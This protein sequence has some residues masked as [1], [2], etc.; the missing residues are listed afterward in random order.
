MGITAVRSEF[1]SRTRLADI[2]PEAVAAT[3]R[4]ILDCLGLV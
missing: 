2:S 3:E 1:V 4:D